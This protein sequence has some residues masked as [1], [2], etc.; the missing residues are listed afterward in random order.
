MP[1][2]AGASAGTPY[3][4]LEDRDLPKKDQV[5]FQLGIFSVQDLITVN[6][7]LNYFQEKA[8]EDDNAM[9]VYNEAFAMCCRGWSKWT[10]KVGKKTVP[11]T[12]EDELENGFPSFTIKL[13]R[14]IIQAA[15]QSNK[16]D[17]EEVKNLKS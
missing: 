14:E 9:S 4:C 10:K 11:I 5:V 6:K 2:P 8:G 15:M 3:I 13:T 1:R 17:E 12:Y 16:L 7:N